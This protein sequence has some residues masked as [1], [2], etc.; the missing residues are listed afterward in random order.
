[1][2]LRSK[3]GVGHRY[4]MIEKLVQS[5]LLAVL[6]GVRPE[7]AEAVGDAA[8]SAGVKNLEVTLDSPD[9]YRSIESM[10]RRFGEDVVVA[11]G[12]VLTADQAR[13]AVAAGAQM[14]VAPNFSPAV[15]AAAHDAGCAAAP[16][17]MTPSEAFAALECGADALKL[18]PGDVLGPAGVKAM[19]AVLPDGVRL[20]V[21][22]GV[23]EGR[24]P[25]FLAAGADVLGL[26]SAL[27][28]PGKSAAEVGA[29]AARFV[30][31]VREARDGAS[32]GR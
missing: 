31:A 32:S 27:F 4:G 25:A 28:K 26:G 13:C 23:D 19:R 22:G 11:A 21:T 5:P 10:R 15:V 2:P 7:E 20:M 9:P 6:R 1:M 8:V 14:I 12:T 18:F 16:G 29:A 17:V 30:A 24:I 3:G